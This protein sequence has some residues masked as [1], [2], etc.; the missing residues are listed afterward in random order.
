MP[1][2]LEAPTT[3]ENTPEAAK[4][5]GSIATGEVVQEPIGSVE[6]FKH[7]AD[8]DTN[9]KLNSTE[10]AF[11]DGASTEDAAPQ[12]PL[13][14]S[15]L[16]ENAQKAQADIAS[17]QATALEDLAAHEASNPNTAK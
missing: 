7:F 8:Q 1:Q 9:T 2:L 3:P 12:Y 6:D 13:P 5:A 16:E 14:D 4:Q 11:K 15:G 17:E 10:Q